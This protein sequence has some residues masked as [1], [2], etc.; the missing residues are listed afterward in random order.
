MEG[1]IRSVFRQY[2]SCSSSG[3]YYI[4]QQNNIYFARDGQVEK[5][6][7]E[8]NIDYLIIGDF[9]NNIYLCGRLD[10]QLTGKYLLTSDGPSLTKTYLE[11][12]RN[13]PNC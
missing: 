4:D 2:N 7:E 9:D 8:R 5:I 10:K 3:K 11:E 1:Y 13:L 6:A 12:Q